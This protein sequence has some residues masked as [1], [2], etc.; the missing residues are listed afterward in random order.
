ML[1]NLAVA[2]APTTIVTIGIGLDVSPH[3]LKHLASS[4]GN[5]IVLSDLDNTKLLHSAEQLLINSVSGKK[6]SNVAQ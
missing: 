4:P 5:S 2:G 3:E 1:M 6:H